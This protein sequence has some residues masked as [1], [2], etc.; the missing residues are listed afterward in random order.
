MRLNIR[1]GLANQEEIGMSDTKERVMFVF[2]PFVAPKGYRGWSFKVFRWGVAFQCYF[3]GG[4][5]GWDRTLT[6]E[7]KGDD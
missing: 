4:E 2:D 1:S 7:V 6:F 5:I 3:F